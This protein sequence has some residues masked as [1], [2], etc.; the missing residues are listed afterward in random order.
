MP[1]LQDTCKTKKEI[2]IS[3]PGCNNKELQAQN[4][5]PLY[6][7]FARPTS[8]VSVEGHSP[9]YRF[10]QA[11]LITN[12]ND[13]GNNDHAEAT[14]V[15]PDLETL[16]ATEAYGLTF[17]LVSRGTKKNKGRVGKNL[18]E[19]S[20]SDNHVDLSSLQKF[21][22][23]CFWGKIPITLL[24]SSLETCADLILGHIVESPLSICMNPGYLEPKFLEHDSC[25]SFC[26]RKADAMGP[27]QLEVKVS[28]AEAG[29]KDI[30]KSPYN[31]F[32]YSDVPQS[33][34]LSIVR[35]RVGNVLF[36][37][38]N[39][40]RSE[41]TEDFSCPFCLVR[42]GNFKGLECHMISSHDLFHFEFWISEDYQAVNVRLKKDNKR[43]EFVSGEVDNSHQIFYYRSRFKKSKRTETLQVAHAHPHITE[44]GSLDDMQVES[45]E[46]VQEEKENASIDNSKKL[47]GSNHT[48]SEFLAFGKSRKLSAN[49]ADPRNRLL[50]QKRQF[51]HSHKAQPMTF[52]E[53]LSDND[54]EDEVDD[55]IADL[56]DRRMLDDFVDV[57]KDEKRIMHMW[58]SFVR[59]QSILA[60]SHV[61]WACEAFSR[62]HG[63]ELVQNSALLWGWR[64][65]MIKL[66]N[67][68]LLDARAM[69]TC[70]KILDAI[71]NESSDPKKH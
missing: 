57:T 68:S 28:A 5:F 56:E 53:V 11:C 24:N 39:T 46:D 3:L 55:D 25:L 40:Q 1:S 29:A 27:Y 38:K 21:A 19:N 60:D 20:S 59:K 12:F 58:N 36:N 62:H 23:K 35:L 15:I 8:N 2:T 7:L 18:V 69:D 48:P 52:E 49:R 10:S 22:G 45:E 71:K 33:L 14:F 63:E 64:L 30:L 44:S 13:S 32:S 43:T 16:I 26:S 4:I 65:F 31:S 67:H 61:P 70:N 42:C 17:I 41:V 47:H 51:I 50:L 54:S 66:W 34:L 9:I 37:Y 6:V